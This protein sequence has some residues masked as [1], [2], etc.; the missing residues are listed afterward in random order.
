MVAP[1]IVLRRCLPWNSLVMF[2]EENSTTSF[3]G[4]SFTDDEES[5]TAHEAE[6]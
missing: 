4:A 1:M 3:F 2:G 6:P 5:L